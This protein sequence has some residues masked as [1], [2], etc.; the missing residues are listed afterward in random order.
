M[1]VHKSC[2]ELKIK[3][4]CSIWS[5]PTLSPP[6]IELSIDFKS[7]IYYYYYYYWY[8][9][10]VFVIYRWSRYLFSVYLYPRTYICLS[11]MF[12][13]R[14]RE[15]KKTWTLHVLRR[16]S[17]PQILPDIIHKPPPHMIHRRLF[18]GLGRINS[19]AGEKKTT[20]PPVSVLILQ[21]YLLLPSRTVIFISSSN[22][23][24]LTRGPTAW[25]IIIDRWITCRS[26]QH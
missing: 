9:Y 11:L 19:L 23:Q 7:I 20:D 18:I 13:Y 16:C 12:M 25:F 3:G 5:R 21:L 10:L 22:Y 1:L 8:Y 6:F 17:G 15:K 2:K 4:L 24:R 14:E 26:H